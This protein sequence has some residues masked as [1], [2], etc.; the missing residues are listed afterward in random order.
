MRTDGGE[1]MGDTS[2]REAALAL[3]DASRNSASFLSFLIFSRSEQA[4]FSCSFPELELDT[5]ISCINFSNLTK[6]SSTLSSA[7]KKPQQ[8][9]SEKELFFF[10]N[11]NV[12]ASLAQYG[13]AIRTKTNQC[14][15]SY[16]NYFSSSDKQKMLNK[17][18]HVHA[19]DGCLVN[20]SL[21]GS[22]RLMIVYKQEAVC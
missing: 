15:V 4:A 11:N 14:E 12:N 1:R 22:C 10:F 19:T 20:H 3:K 21:L 16:R 17:K 13:V 6:A 18:K 2:W 5:C 7:W 9:G 8:S